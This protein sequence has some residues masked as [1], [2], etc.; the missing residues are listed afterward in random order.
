MLLD[1]M[2]S[3]VWEAGMCIIGSL[4][5]ALSKN[6]HWSDLYSY[7]IRNDSDLL[8]GHDDTERDLCDQL[9]ADVRTL[10]AIKQD[11]ERLRDK[12]LSYVP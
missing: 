4:Y 11:G 3:C 6:Q 12:I 2:S 7:S 10:M 1:I 8:Q 9:E 5:D